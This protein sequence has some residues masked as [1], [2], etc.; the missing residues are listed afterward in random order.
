MTSTARAARLAP[1]PMGGVL[2]AQ[3]LWAAG[4][5]TAAFIDYPAP[6]LAFWRFTI[7]SLVYAAA[8]AAAGRRITR[9]AL[10]A[11]IE[12]GVAFAA[13]LGLIYTALKLTT[14]A[15]AVVIAAL[16]PV[17]VALVAHRLFGERLPRRA[18]VP[19][20]AALGGVVLVVFGATGVTEWSLGGDLTALAATACWAWY[21]VASKRARARVDAWRYQTAILIVGGVV[22][23]P[24]AL[25]AEGSLGR[26]SPS[27]LV[28]VAV[29]IAVPGTGHLLMNWAHPQVPITVSSTMTLLLPPLST[30]GAVIALDQGVV[31]L[32]VVGMVVVLG[33]LAVFI[34]SAH[35]GAPAS[36]PL[37]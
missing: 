1:G 6:Q 22:L 34:R 30:V 33:A 21:F 37:A 28:G 25:V 18:L 20:A 15:N 36:L 14:V 35:V 4:N 2:A 24:F 19:V 5:V 13:N 8:T 3:F 10:G 31:V 11:S 9:R 12:G 23:A 7:G 17:M 16:Q 27:V 26:P 29:L 32:Q